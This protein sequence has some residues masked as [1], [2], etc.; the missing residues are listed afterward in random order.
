MSD[1][2]YTFPHR[3][4]VFTAVLV[5]L[6]FAAFGFLARKIYVPHAETV[7]KVE[8][9]RSPSDRKTLLVEHRTAETAALTTYGWVDQKAGVARLPIDRAIELT[10]RDNVKK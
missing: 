2:N 10:V 4:P 3:T 9:V 6:A 8:G 1:T 7:D 5:I